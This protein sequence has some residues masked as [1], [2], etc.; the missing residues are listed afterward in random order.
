MPH[1]TASMVSAAV[2]APVAVAPVP[3]AKSARYSVA[4]SESKLAAANCGL[5]GASPIQPGWS[6]PIAARKFSL[7]QQ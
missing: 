2:R 5:Y 3:G 7:S 6:S 4:P 1:A